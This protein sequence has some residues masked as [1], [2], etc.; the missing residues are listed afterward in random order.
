LRV[1]DLSERGT[2]SDS[3][4]APL[5]KCAALSELRL[6]G[7]TALTARAFTVLGMLPALQLLDISGCAQ[8]A[9][10]DAA[11]VAL[12]ESRTLRTL[13]MRGCMQASITDAAFQAIA[14][15]ATLTELNVRQCGGG[16]GCISTCSGTIAAARTERTFEAIAALPALARLDI[17][18]FGPPTLRAVEA[19]AANKA[20]VDLQWTWCDSLAALGALGASSTLQRLEFEWAFFLS[21]EL[22]ARLDAERA[23]LAQLARC[24]TLRRLNFY[25]GKVSIQ[26]LHALSACA[27]LDTLVLSAPQGAQADAL[28]TLIGALPNV[29]ELCLVA[30]SRDMLEPLRSFCEES[31]FASESGAPRTLELPPVPRVRLFLDREDGLQP[32]H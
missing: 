21:L 10:G 6:R 5:A 8:C 17:S 27:A 29:W 14:R 3:H 31:G 30:A 20:L 13:L 26:G 1:L 4:I 9:L 18:A 19:L 24:K 11:F 12:A 23:A 25:R 22:P 16:G 32:F 2:L 7:C 15:I 28:A